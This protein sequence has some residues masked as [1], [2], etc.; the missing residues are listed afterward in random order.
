MNKSG[1]DVSDLQGGMAG[2][3]LL[4]GLLRVGDEIEVRPGITTKA[5]GSNG[6]GGNAEHIF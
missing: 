4:Q 1:Q 2:G 5:D 3:P 6:G